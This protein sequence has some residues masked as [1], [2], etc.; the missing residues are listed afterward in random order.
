MNLIILSYNKTEDLL[1]GLPQL[2]N[3]LQHEERCQEVF[4]HRAGEIVA[5]DS[6][7]EH[8]KSSKEKDSVLL[9]WGPV[10]NKRFW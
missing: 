5:L 10:A 8:S 4:L 1:F 7:N 2:I 9:A 6:T 3:V